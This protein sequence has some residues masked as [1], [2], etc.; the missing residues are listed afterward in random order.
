MEPLFKLTGG[1]AAADAPGSSALRT[2]W[3]TWRLRSMLAFASPELEALFQVY[4][5]ASINVLTWLALLLSVTLYPVL[6]MQM[7]GKGAPYRSLLPP[8]GVPILFHFLP[9][10]AA[11]TLLVLHPALYRKYR[12][13]L[14]IAQGVCFML[15]FFAVRQVHLWLRFVDPAPPNSLMSTA[16]GFIAENLYLAVMWFCISGHH[17]GPFFDLAVVLGLLACGMRDN[18][19][20]CASPL[21]PAE[22]VTMA[23]G[24][25]ALA[26]V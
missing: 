8:L 26:E 16:Q 15:A 6:L 22:S 25:T 12:R 21:W 13:A 17:P 18:A 20:I 2:T 1:S 24:M 11:L 10:T 19:A 14:S 7:Y 5:A 3:T 4:D 23:P 9:A